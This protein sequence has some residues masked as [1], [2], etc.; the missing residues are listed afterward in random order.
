M[1]PEAKVATFLFRELP[2]F[3]YKLSAFPSVPEVVLLLSHIKLE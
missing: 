2:M 3:L 1:L